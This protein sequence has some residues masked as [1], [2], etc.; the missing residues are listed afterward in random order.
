LRAES[1]V[2]AKFFHTS[3]GSL[4]D[5]F[6]DFCE[7]VFP[8]GP[9]FLGQHDSPNIA[10]ENIGGHLWEKLLENSALFEKFR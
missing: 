2:P 7:F 8:N 3:T 1:N 9:S 5:Y 6:F 10:D 4:S